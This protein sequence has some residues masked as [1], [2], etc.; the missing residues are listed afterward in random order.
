VL[1]LLPFGCGHSALKRTTDV[2]SSRLWD[3][4]KPLGLLLPRSPP[5]YHPKCHYWRCWHKLISIAQGNI[6]GI[7]IRLLCWCPRPLALTADIRPTPAAPDLVGG[8]VGDAVLVLPLWGHQLPPPSVIFDRI[9]L[10]GGLLIAVLAWLMGLWLISKSLQGVYPARAGRSQ[11]PGSRP[12]GFQANSRH[13]G[14]RE[15]DRSWH[16]EQESV[17]NCVTCPQGQA[18]TSQAE[19]RPLP[20]TLASAV[21]SHLN[22][23]AAATTLPEV[24]GLSKA[25]ELPVGFGQRHFF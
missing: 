16:S 6:L 10:P 21:F 14:S 17:F 5:A 15:K 3:W 18:L 19:Q 22:F 1:P 20:S 13:R 2:L 9:T 8:A 25:S 24:S 4:V 11:F 23:L 12:G 7:A